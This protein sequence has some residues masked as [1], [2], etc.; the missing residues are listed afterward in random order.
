MQPSVKVTLFTIALIFVYAPVFAG[1]DYNHITFINQTKHKIKFTVNIQDGFDRRDISKTLH[2]HTANYINVDQI[3]EHCT[4]DD[5]KKRNFE[6]KIDVDDDNSYDHHT[7]RHCGENLYVWYEGNEFHMND[8]PHVQADLSGCDDDESKPAILFAHGYNDS[9]KAFSYFA[10]YAQKKGWRVFRTSVPEDGSISKR[11]HRLNAYIKKAAEI[12]K[13]GQGQLTVAAHSMGG[14]DVRYIVGEHL[15]SAIY[16]KK[17]Y[18][19]ATPHGGDTLGYLASGGSDAARDLTPSHMKEFN[20]K[21]TI[22]DFQDQGIDFLALRFKCGKHGNSDG[23]VGFN[24]QKLRDAP[25]YP[26][27]DHYFK[28]RHTD[29]AKNCLRV[30]NELE[31]EKVIKKILE[32]ENELTAVN[33]EDDEYEAGFEAGQQ[34]CIQNP[35]VCGLCSCP[36]KKAVG[37]DNDFF[38]LF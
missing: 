27:D 6:I 1:H 5:G 38:N 18:T 31:D 36:E 4:T 11:A 17:V 34:S 21:Y 3:E 8:E 2:S 16:F 9:Q 24:N 37:C 28:A 14:L 35:S 15:G 13:I 10:H 33:N 29:S 22:S 12:C 30:V 26:S 25:F 19:I 23:V 32:S 20:K 7:H